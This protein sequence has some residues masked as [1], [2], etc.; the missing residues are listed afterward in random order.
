MSA[1]TTG[2]QNVVVGFS[3][4]SAIS[5]GS[6]NVIA[7]AVAGSILT[8]GSN[9]LI[10]GQRV[11]SVTLQT[12]SSNILLGVD[13]STDTAAAGTS[14]TALIKGVS[15]GTAVL[16]STGTNGTPTTIIGG[17][18]GVTPTAGITAHAGGG[19]ASA[20]ALTTGINFVGTIVTAADSVKLATTATPGI[21]QIVA[22]GSASNAMQVFG[23]GTDTINGIATGTG[24]SV[25]AGKTGIF[26]CY[27]A[28]AWVGGTLN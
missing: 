4:G 3:G 20:T 25:P 24:V 5:S 11:A 2:A 10:L 1:F 9:N 14:N 6:Q 26:F 19:Q 28:G 27:T 7:G 16:S 15:G 8:T 17:I 18:L 12:G 23:L 22:N 13:S 21:V